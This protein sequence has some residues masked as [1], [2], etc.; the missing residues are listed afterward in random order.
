MGLGLYYVYI[1]LIKVPLKNIYY[2][3]NYISI[4][5]YTGKNRW[6]FFFVG[7]TFFNQGG[8]FLVK[9][10]VLFEYMSYKIMRIEAC[11][12]KL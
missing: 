3:Y 11:G 9:K 8:T 5:Y 1:I 7:G 12:K 6:Y 4:Q 2:I 10:V